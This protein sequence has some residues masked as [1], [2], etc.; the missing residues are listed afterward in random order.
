MGYG[1]VMPKGGFA[2]AA[3]SVGTAGTG[4]PLPLVIAAVAV[5][6]LLVAVVVVRTTFRRRKS[7]SDG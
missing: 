6:L 4:V 3:F 1:S 2:L 7:V 5:A